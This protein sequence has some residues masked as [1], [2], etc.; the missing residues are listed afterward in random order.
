VFDGIVEQH[1]IHFNEILIVIPKS[2]S[3]MFLD[4][5][6][7]DQIVKPF[8]LVPI[9]EVDEKKTFRV[10]CLEVFLQRILGKVLLNNVKH[11]SLIG[12]NMVQGNQSIAVNSFRLMDPKFD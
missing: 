3:D 9:W 4:I 10:G 11:D 1:Q 8:V 7:G 12:L 2:I 5:I 6:E